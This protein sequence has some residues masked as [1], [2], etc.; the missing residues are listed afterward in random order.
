[1]NPGKGLGNGDM[2]FQVNDIRSDTQAMRLAIKQS[3]KEN[4]QS[5]KLQIKRRPATFDV[6]I[7]RA[8]PL[9][10]KLGVDISP[11]KVPGVLWVAGLQETGLVPAWNEI[12]CDR[13]I[14]VGDVITAIETAT[15]DS[16][17]MIAAARQVKE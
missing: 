1:M 15:G 7:L 10:Q 14:C 5:V 9:W 2:I 17:A 13:L 12:H 11:D 8:G 6:E 4:C 3:Q 16:K